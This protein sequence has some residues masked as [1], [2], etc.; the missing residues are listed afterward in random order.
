MFPL[1][2]FLNGTCNTCNQAL[3]SHSQPSPAYVSL[4]VPPLEHG[5][6]PANQAICP[7]NNTRGKKAVL[8]DLPKPDIGEHRDLGFGYGS[9]HQSTN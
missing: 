8:Q 4:R 9:Y 6:L 2:G 3:T 1:E 7:C 5:A